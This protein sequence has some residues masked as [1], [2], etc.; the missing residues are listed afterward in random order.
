MSDRN[1]SR[2]HCENA[3]SAKPKN[4]N[5]AYS[6]K[7][8]IKLAM[9]K[10]SSLDYSKV[11]YVDKNTKVIIGCPKHGEFLVNPKYFLWSKPECPFCA[12]DSYNENKKESFIIKAKKVHKDKYD[13]SKVI[14]NGIDEKVCIICPKHGDFIQKINNHLMGAG[15]PKCGN[16]AI[17]NTKRMTKEEFVR[18]SR[19]LYGW[20]FD[21]SKV[22]YKGTEKKVCII[23][24]KHGEF[25]QTP[26]SHLAKNGC[27]K[28][29]ME[30]E[31]YGRRLTLDEFKK[32][33]Q[34][35]HG[36]MYD[37]SK[38]KYINSGQLPLN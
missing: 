18:K 31:G 22:E 32:K 25:W 9:E 16:E 17:G 12:K 3:T 19:E 7:E 2:G 38:V 33:A 13:Y 30:E 15:C 1:N 5:K 8:W 26:H 24:P 11:E 20:K 23:C 35:V 37:Y 6:T 4:R 36:N 27:H 29:N 34:E 21:Y 14:Y 10:N 28:C